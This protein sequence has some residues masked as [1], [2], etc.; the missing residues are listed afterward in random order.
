MRKRWIFLFVVLALAIFTYFK[1]YRKVY[2]S[3]SVPKSADIVLAVDV[4]NILRSVIGEY[5]KHPSRWKISSSK[6]KE[7]INW[8]DVF[9]LPDII[10]VFHVKEQDLG[11]WYTK[12]NI[13]KR[14][15]FD[16]LIALKHFQKQ[17]Y[18]SL[19][20]YTSAELG[21]H[22]LVD[23]DEVILSTYRCNK[24]ELLQLHD[25]L[26]KKQI[27]MNP[28]MARSYFISDDHARIFILNDKYFSSANLVKI[29]IEGDKISIDGE[30]YPK[31]APVAEIP[32]AVDSEEDIFGMSVAAMP[33]A[34]VKMFPDSTKMKWTKT[35][36]LP[37]DS[38][39]LNSVYSWRFNLKGFAQRSDTAITYE[40]DE[41]FNEVPK[42]TIVQSTEPVMSLTAMGKGADQIMLMMRNRELIEKD[43]SKNRFTGFP[44]W[45]LYASTG[46][47]NFSL[48]T[49]GYKSDS[50]KKLHAI[51]DLSMCP[52][53]V[54][55]S[56]YRYIPDNIRS[57]FESTQTL[58][59]SIT[60]ADKGLKLEGKI[61][62]K[63]G[64]YF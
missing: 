12:L 5:I 49:A 36:G 9:E 58:K 51:F 60:P 28:E 7:E 55:D 25:Q 11:K 40:Y 30:L 3:S 24:D 62:R 47:N 21:L 20:L 64:T 10:C 27:W 4:K 43:G 13:K 8:K 61:R 22:F 57:F 26:L 29:R 48:Q 53:K 35:L 19:V 31:N 17:E 23:G 56:L 32:N 18:G 50:L 37:V 46:E 59:L 34:Y 38:V 39:F 45:P 2:D 41:N 44:L 1:L 15:V 16:Q 33:E 52:S 14:K 6:T 42:A 54:P 63:E